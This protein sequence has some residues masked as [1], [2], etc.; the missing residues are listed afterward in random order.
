MS[1]KRKKKN[2]HIDP[3]EVLEGRVKVTS[4]ELIRL[5]H[6]V[7][8][9][10]EGLG[11]K[12]ES[13][14]YK[15]KARLQSLLIRQFCDGLLVGQPDPGNPQMI[16][17]KLQ[18]FDGDACH[19]LLPE[20]DP[21]ARSWA[22][23]QIDEAVSQGGAEIGE[24]PAAG[25]HRQSFDGTN[26]GKEEYSQ[27]QLIDLGRQAL[28][29]YDYETC[30]DYF[31][32]AFIM[33][34]GGIEAALTI[35]EFYV[36]HLAL[37]EKAIA[38]ADSLSASA[39]KDED[40]KILLALAAS[41]LGNID[42]A[43]DFL[44]SLV[45]PRASE[46]YLLGAKYFVTEG[47]VHRAKELQAVL[48][49]F[50]LDELQPEII[51]LENDIERL[52]RKSLEPAE[53]EM[54][55]AWQQGEWEQAVKLARQLL[56]EWPQNKDARRICNE[57][58]R[59]Q[60][61]DRLNLL[62]RRADEANSKADFIEEVELLKKAMALSKDDHG[63]S[64]R[65]KLVQQAAKLQRD[66][67]EIAETIEPWAAGRKK[68]SLLR[69]VTLPGKQRRE[70]MNR[71]QDPHFSWLSQIISAQ[72]SL[73]P[74]KIVEAVLALGES[75]EI[76][77]KGGDPLP[78]VAVLDL[79]SKVLRSVPAAQDILHRAQVMS[80]AIES[81]KAK[82][83]LKK[84]GDLAAVEDFQSARECIDG[85]KVDGLD[86]DN[87]KILAD[88]NAK[89]DRLEQIQ[90]MKKKYTGESARA[91]H[92]SSRDIALKLAGIVEPNTAWH[93]HEKAVYHSA[94]IKKEWSFVIG[95]IEDLPPCCISSGQART[96]E[97]AGSCL[98]P[99]GGHIILVSG[100]DRWVFLGVF[101]IR[102]QEF[103]QAVMFRIPAGSMAYPGIYPAGNEIWITGD[104]GHV[105]SLTLEPPDILSWHDFSEFVTGGNIVENVYVFP[106]RGYLWLHSREAGVRGDEICEVIDMEQRRVE[107]RFKV[108]GQPIIIKTGDGFRIAVQDFFSESIQMFSEQ[109]KKTGT[110]SLATKGPAHAAALHPNGS[111]YVFLPFEDPDDGDCFQELA[112]GDE[113]EENNDFLLTIEKAPDG[114]GTCQ[115]FIIDDSHG[116]LIH[117]IYTALDHGLIFIYFGD[118][119]T[120][121]S[122]YYLA[123][124]TTSEHGFEKLYQVESPGK[125]ILAADEFSQK[126]VAINTGNGGY[127]AVILGRDKPV[128]ADN[129]VD[130]GFK[131]SLPSFDRLMTCDAPTGAMNA[132][133][134]AFMLQIKN[135]PV[136]EFD[137]LLL[138]MTQPDDNDP[139]KIVAFINAL[140]HLLYVDLA[141]DMKTWFQKN[142]PGHPMSLIELA[143][144]AIRER[145]WWKVVTLL[146]KVCLDDLND[147]TACHICHLLGMGL[148]AR[149]YIERALYTW[150]K[151]AT[152]DRGHC[153]LAPYIT[154]AGIALMSPKKRKR[155]MV[156]AKSDILRTLNF[157]EMVDVH[158]L[159][160]EWLEA[161][162]IMEKYNAPSSYDLQVLARFAEAY[163]H[164]SVVPGEMRW[165]CKVVA[166]A[167]Y[168]EMHSNKSMNINQVLPPYIEAWSEL[169]LNDAASRAAQ[170]LDT[171]PNPAEFS[172]EAGLTFSFNHSTIRT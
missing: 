97:N 49:S 112:P 47:N 129:A 113:D 45:Q 65:F 43:L 35:L 152:Y 87:R 64:E 80:N 107:R 142:Y 12:K 33:S 57:F 27:N 163:L 4:H 18:Y 53:Q 51:Q 138:D 61:T 11:A 56:V 91:N 37:Y 31:Y 128:F 82:E 161:I 103:K 90:T 7:N 122:R 86:E 92:F 133:K 109:G 115:P 39:K 126:V 104:K 58:A 78:V 148:F 95:N 1:K 157:F 165:F 69:F 127:Q 125:L 6:R 124:F 170:W 17:L 13:E 93:W 74:G 168:C 158:L 146:E 67:A 159:N 20:L 114:E 77:Q 55:F 38:L 89:L 28:E 99:D 153:D 14:R 105:V 32:R 137:D 117:S 79:H 118:N 154:Y 172:S 134:L 29:E 123:A 21:D 132:A 151:G 150:K 136:S 9:T 144:V 160:K 19:A 84:A 102:E 156:S 30:D 121:E 81:A 100:H 16:S 167:T 8:P 5:I 48:K 101:C 85:V 155:K 23:R 24:P 22:Q 41:R 25:L 71:I 111:D 36:N 94:Q 96:A 70:I 120:E 66:E 149:G 116:E 62:L 140:E 26:A 145:E 50:E 68:E 42:R 59:Q 130:P 106:K 73:K 52:R 135:C 162:S 15:I 147:G 108:K 166:L 60:R 54:L 88:I 75:K 141:K 10:T 44:G 110:F 169:R 119:S 83:L 76:L 164:Q 34:R 2:Q 3:Y 72:S 40:I 63:L 143:S 131:L 171:Q 98:L 139:D 46:V